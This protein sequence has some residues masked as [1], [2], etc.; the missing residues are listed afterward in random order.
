M[1]DLANAPPARSWNGEISAIP[2]QSPRK[3][4]VMM[5]NAARERRSKHARSG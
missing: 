4:T 3:R 1:A 2:Q 5:A